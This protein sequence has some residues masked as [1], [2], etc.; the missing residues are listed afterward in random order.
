MTLSALRDEA[1][2]RP[3]YLQDHLRERSLTS[4]RSGF[5]FSTIY[6]ASSAPFR[7]PT[8]FAAWIAPAG[9]K[10]TSPGLSVTDGFPS[11]SYS[12]GAAKSASHTI[13]QS[14]AV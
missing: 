11:T 2:D 14:R 5:P 1:P 3:P 13:T 12:S 9:M 8:F 10:R 4:V 7:L 6:V